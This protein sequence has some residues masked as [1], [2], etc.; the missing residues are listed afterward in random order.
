M[1]GYVAWL[2]GFLAVTAG[3]W[4]F[5]Y[6]KKPSG[7]KLGP[8][9]AIYS[10]AALNE[11]ID[12][13]SRSAK[14]VWKGW[15]TLGVA[16]FA[17]S[18]AAA[19]YLLGGDLAKGLMAVK[20]QATVMPVVPGLTIPLLPGL[21]ALA[22]TVVVHEFSHAVAARNGGVKVNKLGVIFIL[23]FPIGAFTEP[24]EQSFKEASHGSKLRVLAAGSMA[25]LATAGIV[26][27]LLVLFL[28]G[29]PS[30]PNAVVVQGIIPGTLASSLGIKAGYLIYG[31]NNTATGTLSALSAVLAKTH[32]GQ[33][34]TIVTNHGNLTGKLGSVPAAYGSSDKGFIGVELS[35]MPFFTPRAYL[36]L[37]T[38]AWLQLQ[39]YGFW[40]WFIN[41]NVGIFN[42]LPIPLLDGDQF[43]KEIVATLKER[44]LPSSLGNGI[45][46][47]L[48]TLAIGLLL[49]N[50]IFS[51]STLL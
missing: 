33:L 47:S 9:Y 27:G 5:G 18:T 1:Q 11:L 2:A 24:D 21:V 15:F 16:V 25:N 10:S 3:L 19:I 36:G 50:L 46:L 6:L 17:A 23:A 41:L 51:A 4:I 39:T 7:L 20:P 14:R 29:Y 28:N 38:S 13:I 35:S 30:S 26:L 22:V 40:I 34:I 37:S 12:R 8:G 43:F 32:P 42:A 48:E 45:A 49:A 44:G 31:L